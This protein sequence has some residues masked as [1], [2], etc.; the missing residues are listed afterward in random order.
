MHSDYPPTPPGITVNFPSYTYRQLAVA[1]EAQG[2][3]SSGDMEMVQQIKD[4]VRR[5]CTRFNI[6]A[7]IAKNEEWEAKQENHR[8]MFNNSPRL[9]EFEVK[10]FWT[11]SCS[12]HAEYAFFFRVHHPFNQ[13]VCW[14]RL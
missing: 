13:V 4:E 6:A 14:A 3:S 10:L 11:E 9:S 5:L 7:K 1:L 2:V 12:H 8:E